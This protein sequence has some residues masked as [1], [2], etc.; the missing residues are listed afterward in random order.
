MIIGEVRQPHHRS[1]TPDEKIWQYRLMFVFSW[2]AMT[3]GVAGAKCCIEVKVKAGKAAQILVESFPVA[4]ARSQFRE[5]D[6]TDG[7]FI[8]GTAIVQSSRTLLV[9]RVR[10]IQPPN[11]DGSVNEDHGRVRLS[12]WTPEIL[13][14]QAPARAR[15]CRCMAFGMPALG[16][17]RTPLS[18]SSQ[19]RMVPADMPACLRKSSGIVVVPLLV[20][21]VSVFIGV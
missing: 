8:H 19:A 18:R 7:Q 20:T 21:L 2:A 9:V 3:E 4:S 15:I 5:G 16:R 13:P 6:R 12:S 1:L 14:I 11:N 10:R 17:A